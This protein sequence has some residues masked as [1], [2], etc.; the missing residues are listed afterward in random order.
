MVKSTL[1]LTA[2]AALA[3][4]SL[5]A[6][7]ADTAKEIGTAAAHAG[8]A[9]GAADPQMVRA[10]L[11][12]VLNC[13]EGPGGA[14]FD[15]TP[16]NPCKGQGN[17]AIPDSAAAARPSLEQ[18]LALVKEALHEG[19]INKAKAKAAEAQAILSK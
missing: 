10:H 16:G 9:A 5:A 7:A 1:T 13:L 6:F 2:C 18:A 4:A 11:H 17:G 12:H 19:E 14:D 8:M 15:E 3:L